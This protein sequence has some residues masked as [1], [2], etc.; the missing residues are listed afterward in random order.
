MAKE[1]SH[2]RGRNQ[3]QQQTN[4]EID[5]VC[6]WKL[7]LKPFSYGCAVWHF[8]S[9]DK[10]FLLKLKGPDLCSHKPLAAQI[11]AYDSAWAG[12]SALPVSST[13]PRQLFCSQILWNVLVAVKIAS[14][15][16]PQRQL[17]WTPTVQQGMSIGPG[18]AGH[19]LTGL[20]TWCDGGCVHGC[21]GSLSSCYFFS[22]QFSNL[23]AS[24]GRYQVPFNN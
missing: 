19:C 9:S 15:Q 11:L 21:L 23:S 20:S 16:W 13:C 14:V 18:T 8:V 22:A 1:E 17:H 6:F 24:S 12:I 7:A 10:I 5:A 4:N 2:N 3:N